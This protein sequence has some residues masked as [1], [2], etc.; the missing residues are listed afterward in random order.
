[1]NDQRIPYGIKLRRMEG[2]VGSIHGMITGYREQWLTQLLLRNVWKGIYGE[3]SGARNETK[4][5][6]S[7]MWKVEELT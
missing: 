6:E 7:D 5:R 1:M 3:H 2:S 4:R